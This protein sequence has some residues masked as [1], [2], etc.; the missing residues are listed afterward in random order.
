MSKWVCHVSDV[1]LTGPVGFGV[2]LGQERRL[3]DRVSN[4]VYKVCHFTD[5]NVLKLGNG[6]NLGSGCLWLL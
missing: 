4:D 3:T 6:P 5:E 2:T 1:N